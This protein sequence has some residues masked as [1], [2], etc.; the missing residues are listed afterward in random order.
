MG[1]HWADTTGP[2]FPAGSG[3]F[4]RTM[5][6]GYNDGLFKFYDIMITRQWLQTHPSVTLPVAQPA[7]YPA[8]G[9]YPTQFSVAFDASS[10]TYRVALEGFV[11]R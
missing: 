10:Q 9:Y 7:S 11:H 8:P 6:Y 4:A 5:V 3:G 1:T 2:E